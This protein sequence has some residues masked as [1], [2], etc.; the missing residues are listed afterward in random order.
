MADRGLVLVSWVAVNND[1]YERDRAT[2][3]YR[4]LDGRFIDGPTLNLLTDPDSPYAGRV[5]DFAMLIPTVSPRRKTQRRL[6]M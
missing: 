2:G 5:T 6:I 4:T 3:A 1:P